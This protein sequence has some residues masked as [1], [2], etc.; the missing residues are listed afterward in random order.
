MEVRFATKIL[1]KN[2]TINRCYQAH[3]FE[4]LFRRRGPK[5]ANRFKT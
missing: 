1:L 3:S 2:K 4:M 5:K